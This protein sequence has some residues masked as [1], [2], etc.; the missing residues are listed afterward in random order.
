MCAKWRTCARQGSVLLLFVI[1]AAVG[2]RANSIPYRVAGSETVVAHS[3]PLVHAETSPVEVIPRVAILDS[4]L[5]IEPCSSGMFGGLLLRH[6]FREINGPLIVS[7]H[8]A[9]QTLLWPRI[10]CGW[11]VASQD[12]YQNG[13]G[14]VQRWTPTTVADVNADAKI[15][16]TG[17]GGT[18]YLERKFPNYRSEERRVGKECRSR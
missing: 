5:N 16:D 4:R 8:N 3:T 1:L 14:C 2:N 11:R 6:I 7:G 17:I 13:V 9:A 10:L 18:P 12:R 15:I